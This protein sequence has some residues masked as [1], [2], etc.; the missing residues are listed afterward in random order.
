VAQEKKQENEICSKKTMAMFN[1][2][3]TDD[4]SVYPQLSFAVELSSPERV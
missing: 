1:E 4:S 2:S 3:D